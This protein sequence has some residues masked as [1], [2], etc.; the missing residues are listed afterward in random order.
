MNRVCWQVEVLLVAA[1]FTGLSV[2][3]T[4]MAVDL[5]TELAWI[6]EVAGLSL[7]TREVEDGEYEA[8]YGVAGDTKSIIA[9]ISKGLVD[10]GW[11]ILETGKVTTDEVETRTLEAAR[12]EAKVEIVLGDVGSQ[13]ALTVYGRVGE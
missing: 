11:K 4:G 6:G 13:K 9:M 2:P 7:I 12:G 8:V 10:R 1:L 3:A 5:S